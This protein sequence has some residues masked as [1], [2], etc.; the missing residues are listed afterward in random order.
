MQLLFSS[1]SNHTNPWVKYGISIWIRVLNYFYKDKDKYM[2]IY[3]TD[4]PFKWA[5]GIIAFHGLY[6]EADVGKLLIHFSQ[7]ICQETGSYLP[8]E[9]VYLSTLLQSGLPDAG[10]YKHFVE[11][12]PE[13]EL[14]NKVLEHLRRCRSSYYWGKYWKGWYRTQP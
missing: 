2:K 14:K 4:C 1:E 12:F 3:I 9:V 7:V 10:D 8:V 6:G 5:S 11:Y 13:G